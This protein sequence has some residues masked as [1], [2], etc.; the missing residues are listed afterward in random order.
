VVLGRAWDCW[1]MD[2]EYGLVA[3]KAGCL[4]VGARGCST[5][6]SPIPTTR[7][8]FDPLVLLVS[9]EAIANTHFAK[10]LFG[11]NAMRRTTR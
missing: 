8:G 1:I 7:K 2:D 10:A 5:D 3:M 9:V 11:G 4:T 6:R